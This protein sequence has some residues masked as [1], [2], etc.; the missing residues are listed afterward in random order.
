MQTPIEPVSK[1]YIDTLE[2]PDG[3]FDYVLS[4]LGLVCFKSRVP[5]YSGIVGMCTNSAVDFGIYISRIHNEYLEADKSKIWFYYISGPDMTEN[6]SYEPLTSIGFKHKDTVEKIVNDKFPNSKTSV[7]YSPE[8]NFV[9]VFTKTRTLDVYHLVLS[10]LPVYYRNIY[11]S[12]ITENDPEVPVLTSLSKVTSTQFK[13]EIS[14]ALWPYKNEFLRAQVTDIITQMHAK[15][16]NSARGQ[17]EVAKNDMEYYLSE[18][19][20]RV[21]KYKEARIMLEGTLAVEQSPEQ[22]NELIDYLCNCRE[23][24]NVHMRENEVVF[25]V[26][27]TLKQFDLDTWEMFERRGTIFDGNYNAGFPSVFNRDNRRLLF[28]AIFAEDPLFEVKMCGVYRINLYN[29]RLRTYSNYNYETEDA[30]FKDYIPNP[31]LQQYSCLGD[32]SSRVITALADGDLVRAFELCVHS[33]GAVN[34]DETDQNFRP[35]LGWILENNNK[36]LRRFDGVDMSPTEALLWL[37]DKEKE[38]ETA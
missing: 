24:R 8:T 10:F 5:D 4:M 9:A 2:R 29:N 37:I 15:K 38:N 26:A 21:E 18:Y 36:V 22:E 14:K 19:V 31:H 33:A 34:L 12:P 23:I 27:T 20:T 6:L 25:T 13:Q 30:I 17:V 28:N 16:I 3:E 7:L 1:E 11:T 35:L 32:F